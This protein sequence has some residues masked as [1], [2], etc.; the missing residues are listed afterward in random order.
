[1]RFHR[2]HH[3][4]MAQ[5]HAA[6][7]DCHHFMQ[8][9]ADKQHRQAKCC[10]TAQGIKQRVRL[11]RGQHGGG[12]IQ[13]QDAGAAVEGFQDFN[14]LTFADRQIGHFCPLVDRQPEITA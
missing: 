6:V 8:L 1:M 7:G 14:P 12:F 11:L 9:V 2:A 4:A 13:D 3:A 10:G 5:H